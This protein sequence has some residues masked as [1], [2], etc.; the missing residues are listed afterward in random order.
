MTILPKT[1][2]ISQPKELD[3]GRLL[4]CFPNLKELALEGRR[5][6]LTTNDHFTSRAKHRN[7]L[8]LKI[9]R[10]ITLPLINTFL[11]HSGEA[12]QHLEWPVTSLVKTGG[13][14]M[15]APIKMYELNLPNHH[16]KTLKLT[17]IPY[18]RPINSNP[19]F[20]LHV[21]INAGLT[22]GR[23]TVESRADG[24][25]TSVKDTTYQA[26]DL[27]GDAI[28]LTDLPEDNED[29]T[30]LIITL[31]ELDHVSMDGYNKDIPLHRSLPQP[32]IIDD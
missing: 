24:R 31:K 20:T 8:K 6:K 22:I 7:L 11:H 26:I 15:G 32:T 1:R 12:I 3:F 19:L 2:V 29:L 28:D 21:E 23:Y 17:G 30:K 14:D 18:L 9:R 5:V 25:I 27:T 10:C 4:Y 16:L 13:P